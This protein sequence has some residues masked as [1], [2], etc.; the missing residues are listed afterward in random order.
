MILSAHLCKVADFTFSGWSERE[1]ET[2]R[3][4]NNVI[5]IIVCI[6][7]TFD[8]YWEYISRYISSILSEAFLFVALFS[9]NILQCFDS[10]LYINIAVIQGTGHFLGI[11][12]I[13][14]SPLCRQCVQQSEAQDH[15]HDG[16]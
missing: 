12:F 6:F 4:L 2:E 16:C 10:E 15:R 11:L 1:R 13:I 14:K 8:Q 7:I 9:H 5:V 3:E